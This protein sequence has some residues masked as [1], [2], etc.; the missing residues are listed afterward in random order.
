LY[1]RSESL[2][3]ADTSPRL[4]TLKDLRARGIPFSA[5]WVRKLVNKG[6]FPKPIK[7]GLGGRNLWIESEV[8]AWID[9]KAAERGRHD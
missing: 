2:R 7:L 5:Q 4:L 3:D 8:N 1:E 9:A 6:V